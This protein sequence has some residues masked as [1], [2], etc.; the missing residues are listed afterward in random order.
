MFCKNKNIE[1]EFSPPKLHAGTVSVER[2]IQTLKNFDYRH[3]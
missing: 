3:C 1:I 2:A